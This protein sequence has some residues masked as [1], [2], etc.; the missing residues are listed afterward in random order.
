MK[1][2]SRPDTAQVMLL[3]MSTLIGAEAIAQS[4]PS[5][6][7]AP[8]NDFGPSNP[9]YASSTL[10]FQ[11]PPFDKIKDEDFQPAIEAGIAQQQAEI[12][13]IA[14]SHEPPTFE[15]TIVAM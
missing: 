12:Q 13:A 15:N 6:A 11:A 7:L 9:F 10:P 8:T 3:F 2:S 1:I 5:P 14:S 4:P